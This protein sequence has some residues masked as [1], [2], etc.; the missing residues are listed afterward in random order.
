MAPKNRF[1]EQ[2]GNLPNMSPDITDFQ[3]FRFSFQTFIWLNDLNT[4]LPMQKTV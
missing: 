4:T 1:P 2:K 3:E